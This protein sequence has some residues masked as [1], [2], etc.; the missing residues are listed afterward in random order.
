VRFEA[1]DKHGEEGTFSSCSSGPTWAIAGAE[2]YMN[3]VK[4]DCKGRSVSYAPRCRPRAWPGSGS[5][6]GAWWGSAW[7]RRASDTWNG[8]P[9]PRWAIVI[10][11]LD[12]YCGNNKARF[13]QCQQC[14]YPLRVQYANDPSDYTPISPQMQ[15]RSHI[16]L[17][18]SSC[19]R[20]L[21]FNCI[22]IYAFAARF[23]LDL[24]IMESQQSCLASANQYMGHTNGW[25]NGTKA[26]REL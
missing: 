2:R 25:D 14:L 9:C 8:R 6:S 4:C 21:P 5:G 7:I 3:I 13:R 12:V 17:R 10:T 1:V 19:P 23:G 22:L 16:H 26:E 20:S 24:D 15:F 11:C 18:S